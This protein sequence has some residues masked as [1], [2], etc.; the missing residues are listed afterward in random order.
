MREDGVSVIGRDLA[1]IGEGLK[2]V[3][4]GQIQIDGDVRGDVYG[5]QIVIG[6]GGSVNGVVAAA[7][8]VVRGTVNGTVQGRDVVLTSSAHVEADLLHASLSLEQGAIFEGRSRRAKEG[9]DLAPDLEAL[10]RGD[11]RQDT[12]TGGQP[13]PPPT[14]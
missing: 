5:D 13:K 1:I 7:R 4:R 11:D 9:Q 10:A 2:I 6:E 8:V 14:L 3:T 12:Q